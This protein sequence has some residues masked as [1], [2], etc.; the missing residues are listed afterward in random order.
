MTWFVAQL[1]ERLDAAYAD[2]PH[3]TRLKARLLAAFNVL[4]LVWV[5]VNVAKLFWIRPPY[6]SERLAVNIAFVLV[7][8]W[9]L[10]RLLK[11]RLALAGSGLAFALTAAVH[12]LLFLTPAYFEP[13][14]AAIQLL[15]FDLVF[16]LLTVV[17]ASRLVAVTILVIMIGSLG[18][19][20][21]HALRS[22]TIAGSLTFAADTLIRDGI[23][24]ILFVFFLGLTLVRMIAAADRHSE[25]ALRQ[26]R[27]AK[28]NL[29]ALVA[30]RTRAL[31]VATREAQD[32]SRAKSEFLANMSHEIRTPLNGIIASS[33]LLCHREDLT[34]AA[35]EHVR[36]IAESGDLLLKLLGDILDL[37]KI[38]ARQLHVEQHPFALAT[39][40]ADAAGLLASKA[41][42]GGV[43]FSY[44]VDANLPPHVTGDSY[45]LR[46]VLLNLV[47]NA[48]KFTPSGGRVHLVVNSNGTSDD[49]VFV[50]FEVSDTGIGMDAE[51]QARVFERF[52]QAD[53]STTRRFGGSGLGLAIS[54]H[55]VRLMGGKLEVESAP[56]I[57][58]KFFFSL[59]LPRTAVPAP[60][61]ALVGAVEA[62][63][64]LKVFV[65]EDNAVNRGILS[66]QLRQLGCTYTMARDGEE[67]MA[68]LVN[69]PLPDVILMDCHMPKLDGWETTLRI[70]AWA[71]DADPIR[72][73]AAVLPIVALTAAVL[74]EE[75]QR[76]LEAGMDRFLAKP[77]RLA[78]LRA[79]LL[80]F[81]GSSPSAVAGTANSDSDPDPQITVGGRLDPDVPGPAT[82]VNG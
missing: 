64:G 72:Q 28:E 22:A 25:E 48:I 50:R 82:L 6:L 53:S 61:P 9:S 77:V 35:A 15:A 46:Q 14:G 71:K 75:R 49:S 24:A 37:S 81:A 38:E 27:A 32:S 34:P 80:R 51:T 43:E 59:A 70:R 65:A 78:E 3:F 57:G 5:P 8:L 10:N 44:K 18:W 73:R 74:P 54:S 66:A 23:F 42:A 39:T 7:S 67:A 2:A 20:Y 55:L 1:V 11:G 41:V 29:E 26:T 31:A 79:M 47:S 76:C 40:V 63:L 33:D 16:L 56:G 52:T 30:E 60:A 36:I 45:R 19:F 21:T 13:L 12:A 4:I 62:A 69:A 58:S 17:F 68:V